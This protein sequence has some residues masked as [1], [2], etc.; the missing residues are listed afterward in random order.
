MPGQAPQPTLETVRLRLRPLGLT[1][2]PEIQRLAGDFAVADTT[3]SI[4][5]PYQDGVAE[6]WIGSLAGELEAGRQ[7]V[8]AI[9]DRETGALIGAVGLV[10]HWDHG[11]AE[12]E[13]WIGQP[14]WQRGYATEAAH[15]V[16]DYGFGGLGLHRIHACHFARNPASG[17]VLE[18]LGMRREG[19]ARQ[20]VRR[21]NRFEDLVFYGMLREEFGTV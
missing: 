4:P 2:A 16:L 11:R 10:L 17:R 7:V 19:L 13:Y 8:F 6:E 3:L 12:M 9:T 21:W 5:H 14:Y 18:K 20:H 1:D 15:V